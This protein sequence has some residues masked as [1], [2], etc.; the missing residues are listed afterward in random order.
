MDFGLA[1]LVTEGSNDGPPVSNARISGKLFGLDT[2]DNL[3]PVLTNADG[4]GVIN[5]FK[6]TVEADG[7]HPYVDQDYRRP[8]LQTP[9][10]VSLQRISPAH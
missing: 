6:L 10:T 2:D 8:A 3:V 5:A 4:I 7:F 9:V 1:I